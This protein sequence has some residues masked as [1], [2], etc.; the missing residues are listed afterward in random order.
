MILKLWAFAQLTRADGRSRIIVYPRASRHRQP[1]L[2]Q[3]SPP[4]RDTLEQMLHGLQGAALRDSSGPLCGQYRPVPL[5]ITLAM[6]LQR[7]PA[8]I[9][10]TDPPTKPSCGRALPKSRRGHKRGGRYRYRHEQAGVRLRRRSTGRFRSASK[11]AHS[12]ASAYRRIGSDKLSSSQ[13]PICRTK[14]TLP[15]HHELQ[16]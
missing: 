4:D 7:R 14:T 12:T 1:V 8:A 3:A 15:D 11:G 10:R 2:R 16:Q 5:R 13:A 9:P 6:A